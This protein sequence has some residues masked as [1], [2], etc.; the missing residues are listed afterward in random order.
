MTMKDSGAVVTPVSY[1][2]CITVGVP[3]VNCTIRVFPSLLSPLTLE[4]VTPPSPSHFAHAGWRLPNAM[5]VMAKVR[6]NEEPADERSSFRYVDMRSGPDVWISC[7]RVAR[8][9]VGDADRPC[10]TRVDRRDFWTF[11]G[12]SNRSFNA[13]NTG[14]KLQI[15]MSML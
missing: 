15:R 1:A 14:G 4:P 8:G 2:S 12:L 3:S 5:R 13:F 9:F 10:S 7:R 6:A 11:C